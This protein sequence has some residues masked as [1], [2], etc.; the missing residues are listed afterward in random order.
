MVYFRGEQTDPESEDNF[1]GFKNPGE[2]ANGYSS[3][4][5]ENWEVDLSEG[6]E[7]EQ[8]GNDNHDNLMQIEYMSTERQLDLDFARP[9]LSKTSRD[10]EDL[11]NSEDEDFEIKFV[12]F[13]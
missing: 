5:S 8:I 13:Y 9:N 1:R 7:E 4:Y 10:A 2:Y 3:L 6:P 12:I 11:E